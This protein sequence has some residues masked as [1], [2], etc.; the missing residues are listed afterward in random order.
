M[1]QVGMAIA[2]LAGLSFVCSAAVTVEKQNYQGW[3]NSY[4]ISN[5]EVELV[6]TGDVGPRVIRFGFVGGQNLFKEYKEQLGKSGEAQFQARGG[7][8]LWKAPEDPVATWAP[9]N[10]PV[11]VRQTANGV[12]AREPKEPL[13]G[14]QKEI[15]IRL[16]ASGSGVTVI[17]RLTNGSLFPLEFSAWALTQ[18]A[19]GGTAVTGFPP[20]GKH[21]V[22]LEATNPLVMWAYTDLA[23]KRWTFTKKYLML[24]QDP[25]NAEPQKLGTFNADTWAVYVLNGEAFVK[26]VKADPT[27]TYPDFGCSFET[28]TNDEFLEVETVGPLTK[29]QPG[30]TVEH[31]ESW[32]L[33]KNVRLN[34]KTDAALDQVILPLVRMTNGAR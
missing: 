31:V 34:A 6:V 28:F 25:A 16:A 30:Q 33:H 27:K 21:P 3:R 24:R 2:A 13:T 7:H 26:R 18:M 5:G 8:R 22:N 9:D 12:I 29:L 32:S 11:D 4:R 17:H 23:D 14:L 10:V 19:Q 20:R 15:E 1:A